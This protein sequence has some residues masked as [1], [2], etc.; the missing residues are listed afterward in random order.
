MCS[1]IFYGACFFFIVQSNSCIFSSIILLKNHTY[2]V[3]L[4][5]F[6]RDH[7]RCQRATYGN[8]TWCMDSLANDIS[9]HQYSITCNN[10]FSTVDLLRS[11]F[12]P[13]KSIIYSTT[14]PSEQQ[15]LFDTCWDDHA[16]RK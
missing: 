15:L 16:I 10:D 13:R 14:A 2:S 4:N 8:P 5:T 7:N 11:T 9:N 6:Y 1:L 3:F 12:A